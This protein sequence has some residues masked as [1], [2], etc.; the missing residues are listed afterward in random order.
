MKAFG[1]KVRLLNF[2]KDADELSQL[3]AVQG[4]VTIPA[5]KVSSVEHTGRAC[6]HATLPFTGHVS[7]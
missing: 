1:S 2:L 5:F 3:A 6:K 7:G 4:K